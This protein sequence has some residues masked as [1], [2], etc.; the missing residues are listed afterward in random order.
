MKI[1]HQS[2]PQSSQ[3]S[4]RT[5]NRGF[6]LIELLVVIAIIAILAAILFPA[7]ARARENAR[8]ASCQSN[9][10]QIGLALTQYTQDYD[11][12][13]PRKAWLGGY[14]EPATETTQN[15]F[16]SWVQ[17][18]M[19]SEQAFV[20][21]SDT[22]IQ[23]ATTP[24][25]KDANK[26]SYVFNGYNATNGTPGSPTGVPGLAGKSLAEID[27]PSGTL[28]VSE[29]TDVVGESWHQRQPGLN[30]AGLTNAS[31]DAGNNMCFADG[32]VK[33]VKTYFN[34]SDSS[35]CSTLFAAPYPLCYN[36][37]ATGYQYTRGTP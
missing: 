7:F 22:G 23:G 33:F 11:E 2:S 9:L 12:R 26:T 31:R 16:F 8:R 3:Q 21:P 1:S 37:P 34:P 35:S 4:I 36:P 29:Y 10:K 17:P 30:T 18:Y 28:M 25:Y 14:G 13:M 27:N 32:H 15:M 5:S 24:K 6:T 19:K 20:C